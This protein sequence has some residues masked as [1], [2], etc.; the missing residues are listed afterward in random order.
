MAR[1]EHITR[2][3][4]AVEAIK[5]P[6]PKAEME[7]LHRE[8]VEAFYEPFVL[9]GDYIST[10]ESNGLMGA[11]LHQPNVESLSLEVVIAM[12]MLLHRSERGMYDPSDKTPL[13]RAFEDGY[14][15]RL[16]KRIAELDG[17]WE[18]P[19]VVTFYHEYEKDGYLS[20]WYESSPFTY[21]GRTFAT[22]EHWMM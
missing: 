16:L 19:N 10:L 8:L 11:K 5:G 6:T 15:A 17:T 13:M 7:D 22:S 9:G 14:A 21:W 20:N 12:L 2:F 1:Y 18:R 4:G 3:I